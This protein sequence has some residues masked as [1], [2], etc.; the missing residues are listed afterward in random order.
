MCRAPLALLIVGCTNDEATDGTGPSPTGTTETTG[1]TLPP[2]PDLRRF[3]CSGMDPADPAPLGGRVAL[4]FDDGPDV[5]TTPLVLEVLRAHEVPATFLVLGER[6]ADPDVWPLVD[7]MVAD[8]LVDVGNHSW[9][10]A[11]L[12]TLSLADAADEIDDTTA[13][14][15]TWVSEPTFFR[16]PYGDSTCETHDLA[17]DRGYRVAGWHIDTG[18]WCYAALG[19]P[20]VCLQSDYWRVPEEFE[21]DMIGWTMEQIRRHHGGIVLLHDIHLWTAEQLEPLIEAIDNEGFTFTALDDAASWPNLVAGTPADLPYLGEPCDLADDRCW[22]VEDE[23]WC[24]PVDPDDSASLDGVCTMPCEGLCLDRDGAATTFCA[25]I[26]PEI[27]QCIGRADE[28]N[29]FCDLVPGTEAREF[30]RFVG[31]S[32]ASDATV[33]VCAPPHW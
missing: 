10:H 6:L 33:E 20:G 4:T 13:L 17:T 5:E 2:P 25:E 27:G 26:D 24:E 22:L 12:A 32:G 29:A 30:D 11:D 31:D 8:P 18:D 19:E 16:F 28:V 15:E 14:L 23:A 1:T 3:D 9:D 7:E 21:D